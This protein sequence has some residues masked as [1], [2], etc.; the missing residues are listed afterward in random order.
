MHAYM[1]NLRNSQ[2][3]ERGSDDESKAARNARWKSRLTVMCNHIVWRTNP[4]ID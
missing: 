2:A 3:H 4:V 1:R